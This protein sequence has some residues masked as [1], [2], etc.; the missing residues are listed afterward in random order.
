MFWNENIHSTICMYPGK[1]LR[2]RVFSYQERKKTVT[3]VTLIRLC[4]TPWLNG[5][6]GYTHQ[7]LGTKTDYSILNKI[8]QSKI[9][10]NTVYGIM[11]EYSASLVGSDIG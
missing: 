8:G 6:L 10:N 3:R 11:Q 5:H 1:E 4:S 7:L 9:A 2:S